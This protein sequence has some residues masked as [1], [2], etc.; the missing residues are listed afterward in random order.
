MKI[1]LAEDEPQLNR[2]ITAALENFHHEVDSVFDGQAAVDQ[3]KQNAYDAIIL[4]IMMPVMDGVTALEKIRQ[5]GNRTYVMMLTAKSEIDDKVTGLEAGADD[6]LTKPF[7]LKELVARLNSVQRRA[8]NYGNDHLA[9]GDLQLNT[10]EQELSSKNSIRLSSKETDML[11]YFL[12]NPNKSLS[13][14]ELFKHVWQDQADATTDLV[15]VY[16]SYLRQKLASIQSRT[17]ILGEKGGSYELIK[18]G[19]EP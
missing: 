15:W 17:Q 13:T 16:V 14:D 3:A 11:Q 12:L 6:Y 2:V 8:D 1:L 18:Q 4:D 10:D 9:F 19:E 7:S 5:N